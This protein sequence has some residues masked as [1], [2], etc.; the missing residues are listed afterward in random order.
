MGLRVSDLV[1]GMS[2]FM[3]VIGG[4]FIVFIAPAVF[5]SAQVANHYDELVK[6]ERA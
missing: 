1:I 6:K 5:Y 2:A 4:S 3:I